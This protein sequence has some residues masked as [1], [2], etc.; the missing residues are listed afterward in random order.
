MDQ[1][2]APRKEDRKLIPLAIV[3]A[4]GLI[5]AAIYFGGSRP[6]P[7]A[8]NTNTGTTATI[9]AIAPVSPNE[10]ILGNPAAK[11]LIVEYSDYEC[12]FCKSFHTT[13]HQILDTYGK[14]N[15][16]L[17][18]RHFPIAQLHSK[19]PKEA[20]AAECV[21]EQGGNTAFW[22]FT[23]EIFQ[24]TGSNDTLDP[25]E[26]PKIAADAGVDVQKFNTCLSSGKY[27]QAVSDAV[28][29]AVKAG[30]QGTP[31]SVVIF[32]KD[33]SSSQKTAILKG[34]G[35]QASAVTFDPAKK[36]MFSMN[37][38]LSFPN[39]KAAFDVLLK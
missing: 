24:K 34:F 29:A 37:G 23:D 19:A 18:Y 7:I 17:V 11:V 27:T 8:P 4:G 5:A 16:A 38:A 28:A 21:A 1:T 31:Y 35:N 25:L 2:S 20:E 26:L 36:N 33:V 12:P 9:G 32:N 22:K 15:V 3:V 14:D 39:I 10:H 6:A 30:G 13:V